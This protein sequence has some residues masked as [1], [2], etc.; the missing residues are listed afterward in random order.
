MSDFATPFDAPIAAVLRDLAEGQDET[1]SVLALRVLKQ[2][3]QLM[4]AGT[5]CYIQPTVD[6]LMAHRSAA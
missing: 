2:S 4:V 3:R 1:E 5:R 6:A